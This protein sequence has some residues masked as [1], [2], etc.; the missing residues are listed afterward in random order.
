H[1]SV[2]V[3]VRPQRYSEVLAAL[4]ER[5]LDDQARRRLAAE[6]YAHTS[7]YDAWIAAYLRREGGNGFPSEITITGLLA[8][9][10]KYGENEHQKAAFYRLGPDPGGLGGAEQVQGGPPGSRGARPW[11]CSP[12]SRRA[13]D[14]STTTCGPSR[15]G[16]SS[17]IGTV[18]ASTARR[19]RRSRVASRP[20]KSGLS[21]ASPGPRSSTSSPMRSSFSGMGL[22]SV[23]APGRCHASRRCSSRSTGPAVG[24]GARCWPRMPSFRFRTAWSWASAPA[25][26][27]WFSQVA[28]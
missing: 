12:P 22:P 9:P 17:R 8:Q 26:L 1:Q 15:A 14:C 13:R 6:A 5:T 20:K 7:A 4:D 3:V 23:S 18:R 28:R 16:F 21:S 27:R 19:A 24:P 2:V 25:S 10:L 11:W